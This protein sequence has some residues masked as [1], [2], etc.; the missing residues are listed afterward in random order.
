MNIK[1]VP[2]ASPLHPDHPEFSS[3]MLAGMRQAFAETPIH[4]LLSINL[5]HVEKG[6]AVTSMPVAPEA[7]NSTGNL[8]GGAIATLIDVAAGSAAATAGTFIPGQNHLVTADLHIRYLG[9]PH[10]D[11]ITADARVL[12]AGRQLIVVECR[13]TDLEARMIAS[14]DFAGMAVPMREPLTIAGKSDNTHPDL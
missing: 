1:E 13:V 5:D 4:K 10:G 6:W 9:R 11:R 12:R 3:L 2:D 7:F 14:A 8:H